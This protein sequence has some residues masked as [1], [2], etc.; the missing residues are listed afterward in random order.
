MSFVSGFGTTLI[1]MFPAPLTSAFKTAPQCLQTT[2]LDAC[3]CLVFDQFY[4]VAKG[5]SVFPGMLV[6]SL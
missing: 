6:T 4:K 3:D 5:N 2:N 1:N